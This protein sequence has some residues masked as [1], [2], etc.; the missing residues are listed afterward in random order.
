MDL[1]QNGTEDF[2]N[3]IQINDIHIRIISDLI[4][5][6]FALGVLIQIKRN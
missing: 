4:N 2:D 3:Y 6:P 1:L 5:D